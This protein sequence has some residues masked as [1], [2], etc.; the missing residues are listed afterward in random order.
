MLLKK[1]IDEYINQTLNFRTSQKEQNAVALDV[2]IDL[3][4]PDL[5]YTTVRKLLEFQARNN[6]GG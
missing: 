1:S 4:D 6:N 3:N 2:I 5:S